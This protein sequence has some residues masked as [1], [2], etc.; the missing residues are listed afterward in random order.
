M[1]SSLGPTRKRRDALDRKV[2][3][4]W[5][6]PVGRTP[7][8]EEKDAV[9]KSSVTL[10]PVTTPSLTFCQKPGTELSQHAQRTTTRKTIVRRTSPYSSLVQGRIVRWTLIAL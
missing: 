7:P 5:D 6:S 9:S 4:Y 10:A 3:E 8:R 2:V 1:T